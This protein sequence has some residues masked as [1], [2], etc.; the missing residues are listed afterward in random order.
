M[1]K[2]FLLSKAIMAITILNCCTSDNGSEEE[3]PATP[4]L[5]D[6]AV[7]TAADLINWTDGKNLLVQLENNLSYILSLIHI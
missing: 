3:R 2:L 7:I 6:I 5:T 1:K 4:I